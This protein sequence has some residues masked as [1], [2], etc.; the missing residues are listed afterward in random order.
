MTLFVLPCVIS[1]TGPPLRVRDTSRV[2]LHDLFHIVGW[3]ELIRVM[4]VL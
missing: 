1:L 2:F 3:R 4:I